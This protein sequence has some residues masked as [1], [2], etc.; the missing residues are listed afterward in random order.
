MT[1]QKSLKKVVRKE[2]TNLEKSSLREIFYIDDTD[3]ATEE[4]R[5]SEIKA[6]LA[7]DSEWKDKKK[8]KLTEKPI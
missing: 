2:Y 5:A 4:T 6:Q 1:S 8:V 3:F 7:N